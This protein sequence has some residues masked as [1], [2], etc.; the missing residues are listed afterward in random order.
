MLLID[1]VKQYGEHKDKLTKVFLWWFWKDDPSNDD[2]EY[3]FEGSP[4]DFIEKYT[5]HYDCIDG[6][7]FDDVSEIKVENIGC[8]T[9]IRIFIYAD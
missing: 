3:S 4:S 9:E 7:T 2:E 8:R 1:F 6:Y 5:E